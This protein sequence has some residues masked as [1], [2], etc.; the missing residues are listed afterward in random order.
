MTEQEEWAFNREEED[1]GAAVDAKFD[2]D[3]SKDGGKHDIVS[4]AELRDEMND[5][6]LYHISAV[7][8]AG[9]KGGAGKFYS[10]KN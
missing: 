1:S 7:S 3:K 6:F 2:T 10:S 8:Y 4:C 9:D 5:E